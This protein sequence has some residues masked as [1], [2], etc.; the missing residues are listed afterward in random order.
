MR[1]GKNGVRRIA[2][3]VCAAALAA[4]LLPAQVLAVDEVPEMNIEESVETDTGSAALP[5]GE[6]LS[7]QQ[8][9]EG[10]DKV[11]GQAEQETESGSQ[12][13]AGQEE[14]T[15]TDVLPPEGN[16][17]VEDGEKQP[18]QGEENTTDT[19]QDPIDTEEN[20]VGDSNA[21][22]KPVTNSASEEQPAAAPQAVNLLRENSEY[23]L[24][25]DGYT[26]VV[27][28]VS[29][30]TFNV[31]DDQVVIL[32]GQ[33][34]P[35]DDPVV[36]TNCTFN[37][38]G[39]TVKL[40]GNIPI[41]P[42]D[43]DKKLSYNNGEV[44]TKLWIGGNVRFDNCTFVT[45]EGAK[46]TSDKEGFDACIYFYSGDIVLNDCK[47][48]ATDYEGQFLGLYGASGSVTFNDS[49][50][51]T[52]RN[53]NGWSYAMYGG[54]VLKLNRSQMTA[55]GMTVDSGNTNVFYSGDNKKDYDAIFF[56]DS[57]ID[58]SDNKA[59]GFA[60]NRVNIY[61]DNSD[62][63]VNN[64]SGNACNSGYWKVTN[65]SHITMNGNR[66]GHALS[67]IGFEMSDSTLEILHNGYA[68]IYVQSRNSSLTNCSVDVRCNG[69]KLLSYS[70]G[71][72]WLNGYT[73]TVN[74]GTSQAAEGSPWLG[75]VGRKGSVV[76]GNTAVV[77]YDL[78]ENAI[79]NL[80]SN[81]APTLGSAV[82]ALSSEADTH[83]LLL[84]PFM[85]SAYARGN[86]EKSLSNNDSDLFTTDKKVDGSWVPATQE[87]ILDKDNAKI[88]ALTTAQLAHHNY[89]WSQAA[90]E[91]IAATPDQYGARAYACKD[92]CDAYTNHTAEHGNSFDC[93]GTYVYAP[94]VGI[95]F[96]ANLPSG[97]SEDAL[98]GMPETVDTF[99]YGGVFTQPQDPVLKSDS[100]EFYYAFGGWYTD[101]SCTTPFDFSQELTENWTTVYAKWTKTYIATVQPAEMT[102][103][104][105]GTEGYEGSVTDTGKIEGSNSLPEPGYYITLPKEIDK[106]LADAGLQPMGTPA[107]LSEI[108]T[109]HTVGTEEEHVWNLVKYGNTYSVAYNKYIYAIVPQEGTDP[110]RLTYT[111]ADGVV[112]SSDDFDLADVNALYSDYTMAVYSELVNAKQVFLQVQIP[113]NAGQTQAVTYDCLMTTKPTTLHVRYVTGE[114]N[115][116]V[117]PM[118]DDIA[119]ASEKDNPNQDA[120][121]KAYVIKNNPDTK[122]CI[123]GSSVDVNEENFA[124]VSLLF[125]D[126]VSSSNTEGADD[127]KSL[128]TKKAVD[129][130]ASGLENVQTEAKYLDLVDANNG[131]VWLQPSEEVTVYWPYPA[132]TDASTDFRLVHF[133]GLDRDKGTEDVIEDIEATPAMI[134]QNLKTDEYGIS[135][136]TKRFSPFV[137]VWGDKPH[138]GG[139]SSN[140]P[141]PT[142]TPKP[143]A[144]PATPVPTATPAA[145]TTGVIP[146]TGDTM[147]VGLLGGVAVVAA[148]ALAALVVLRKRKHDD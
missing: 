65:D 27:N 126:V 42:N 74:G 53:K 114:Q 97:V 122:F 81:T 1:T 91:D 64:N 21:E 22:E 48:Q 17:F 26:V 18:T 130:V 23:E 88:G 44:I 61:V 148:A 86:A 54:S 35:E 4:S 67:C 62:I 125:D 34:A 43:E 14:E 30:A 89:D 137:L 37:L 59:G 28:D 13:A 144:A 50:I 124:Q 123:N 129:A 118:Y 93:S 80:K 134:V 139:G 84:N 49:E 76:T 96:E 7:G 75:A 103:Y 146:S 57:T 94:L 32:C 131:N 71:D 85:T 40:S 15:K 101:A 66:G 140:E 90:K 56:K 113:D 70:A 41:D 78:N 16:V 112:T 51:S 36:F 116:V 19:E 99:L 117:T 110:F 132:G 145:V 24:V 115:S 138:Q 38:S 25:P 2:A 106:A 143:T 20:P 11:S 120:L 68:G 12:T 73:L 6:Q 104:M 8:S 52:I 9:A 33:Q 108:L 127:Y 102:I 100:E 46:K 95:E 147:P 136:T 109:I 83:T 47:L 128:L 60:I 58:F 133:E 77:A 111:D 29:D 10:E 92:V 31:G 5:E 135:F 121:T 3:L 63:T 98:S 141:Q 107:D 69:E 82:I 87:E 72:I 142:Q 55:T 119:D 45:Q 39:G 79:D 105:G